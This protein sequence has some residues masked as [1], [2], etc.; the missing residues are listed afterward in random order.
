[1]TNDDVA[2]R[3]APGTDSDVL[4]RLDAGTRVRIVGGQVRDDGF[5]WQRVEL[6]GRTGW[7]AS[8]FLDPV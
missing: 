4:D 6:A 5:T 3:D 8:E 2:L 1:V 7:V